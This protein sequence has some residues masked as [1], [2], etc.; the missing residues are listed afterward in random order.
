MSKPLQTTVENVGRRKFLGV[1]AATAGV[2][3]VKPEL[4]FGTAANSA[5]P[6]MASPASNASTV[7]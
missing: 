6:P 7:G 2:M 5:V 4:V 3:L 1:S